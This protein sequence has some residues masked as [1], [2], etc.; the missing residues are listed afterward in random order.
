MYHGPWQSPN[1]TNEEE[2]QYLSDVCIPYKYTC[3][4]DDWKPHAVTDNVECVPLPYSDLEIGNEHPIAIVGEGFRAEA[5][6]LMWGP[7]DI[8]PGGEYGE[9]IFWRNRVFRQY[10]PLHIPVMFGPLTHLKQAHE[11]RWWDVCSKHK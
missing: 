11:N 1:D 4:E 9:N 5:C 8:E 10:T 3:W 6:L 7:S 2:G